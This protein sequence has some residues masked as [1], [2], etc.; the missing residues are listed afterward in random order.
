MAC[1][2]L[3]TH[4]HIHVSTYTCQH[5]HVHTHMSTYTCPHTHVHTHTQ[6]LIWTNICNNRNIRTYSSLIINKSVDDV[7]SSYQISTVWPLAAVMAVP[8]SLCD[9]HAENGNTLTPNPRV[10]FVLIL[11]KEK[12]G[13]AYCIISSYQ[14][15]R[16]ECISHVN[17]SASW[18]CG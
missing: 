2:C 1:A 15:W 16:K 3:H 12:E 11:F 18:T 10:A 4:A 7:R 6:T 14:W 5:I 13:V 9:A 8:I 17:G